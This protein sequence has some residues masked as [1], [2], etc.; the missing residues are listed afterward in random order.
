M[1]IRSLL[2]LP[3]GIR[4]PSYPL[5]EEAAKA[6]GLKLVEGKGSDPDT[7]GKKIVYV[8]DSNSFPFY[9]AEV[10]HQFHDDFQSPPYGKTYNSLVKLAFEHGRVKDTGC[11][12]RFPL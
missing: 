11:P 2:G 12:D 3:G 1:R 9:Q 5:I 4:H 6:R 7:L 8:M 10:Y